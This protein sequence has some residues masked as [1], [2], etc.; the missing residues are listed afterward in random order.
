MKILLPLVLIGLSVS[1][2]RAQS[3]VAEKRLA[4]V[5]GNGNYAHNSAL[6][7]ATNDADDMAATLT[8]LGFEVL[9]HKDVNKPAMQRAIGEFNTKLAGYSVGL[10]YYV[11]HGT[12]VNGRHFMAPTDANPTNAAEAEQM[13]LTTNQLIT[14]MAAAKAQTN[15]VILDTDRTNPF[16]AAATYH[17]TSVSSL[18]DVGAPLGFVVA[19]ATAPGR[20]ALEG[21]GRNGV[22][23]G[24]LLKAMAVPNQSVSELFRHVRGEVIKQS[25]NKQI[26]WESMSLTKDFYFL[27]K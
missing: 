18:Y 15:I 13:C 11:G 16:D 21:T 7:K 12:E 23:T 24:A 2:V 3:P 22:Y 27:K 19:Y 1:A 17:R 20:P 26:P 6:P 5:M 9:V 10:V 8:Q 14:G 25:G 4:L